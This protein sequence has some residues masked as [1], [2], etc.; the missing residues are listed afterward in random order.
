[1]PDVRALDPTTLFEH[2]TWMRRLAVSL[3]R[4]DA[5]ADDLVQDAWSVALDNPPADG[6]PLKAWLAGILKNQ[7]RGNAR[8]STHRKDRE[9]DAAQ[10]IHGEALVATDEIVASIEEQRF[11]F[12][13]VLELPDTYREV[14]LLRF[15]EG[16]AP[17]HI[18]AHLEI[19]VDTVRT[20]IRR[21]LDRLREALDRRHDGDRRAW[22]IAL[23]P[24]AGMNIEAKVAAAG[25]AAASAAATGTGSGAAGTGVFKGWL[26]LKVIVSAFVAFATLGAVWN[27]NRS[28]APLDLRQSGGAESVVAVLDRLEPAAPDPRLEPIAADAGPPA[29]EA[30]IARIRV[31]DPDGH[32]IDGAHLHRSSQPDPDRSI[33]RPGALRSGG[34]VQT[35]AA[36]M[37]EVRLPSDGAL[38]WIQPYHPD[39][40]VEGTRPLRAGDL[41]ITMIPLARTTLNLEVVDRVTGTELSIVSAFAEAILDDGAGGEEII[42][43]GRCEDHLGRWT[44]EVRYP[45]GAEIQV[46]AMSFD[47]LILC[48][49]PESARAVPVAGGTTDFR[50]KINL[51]GPET[52]GAHPLASGIVKDSRTGAPI[53]GATI[54]AEAAPGSHVNGGRTVISRAD[55]SFDLALW[56]KPD[57]WLTLR[58]THP[59]FAETRVGLDAKQGIRIAMGPKAR[60]SGVLIGADGAPIAGLP[61]DLSCDSLD[62]GADCPADARTSTNARGAFEFEYLDGGRYHL[63]VLPHAKASASSAVKSLSLRV[64]EGAQD[65]IRIELSRRDDVAVH[66]E[67]LHPGNLDYALTPLFLPEWES[68]AWSRAKPSAR[69][70]Y[71]AGLLSPG[72][73]LVFLAPAIDDH[74]GPYALLPAVEVD[75]LGDTRIDLRFPDGRIEGSIELPDPA[76]NYRVVIVP[77][78]GSGLAADFL[79]KSSVPRLLGAEV[80]ANGQF[81][82]A[83]VAPGP[84]E[85]RLYDDSDL[86]APVAVKDLEIAGSQVLAR[87]NP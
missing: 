49:E 76:V 48:D 73:Y 45:R 83:G 11:L 54:Q 14:V 20:R 15:H 31:V 69:R 64:A 36:G 61:I 24:L 53:A 86:S 32:P 29:R 85:I 77:K 18:A 87:W 62:A 60:V 67:V 81:V 42:R 30:P 33:E 51:E 68:G 59:R 44:P 56:A 12:D 22:G 52:E 38:D 34:S 13:A 65:A 47:G 72:T 63:H 43:L 8:K 66:G 2:T 21:G 41:E 50:I 79:N 35:D 57:T 4:D 5:R 71:E 74:N 37:A 23:L 80:A 28:P 1:M 27:S 3:V 46:T 17:R 10:A 19:P 39:F 40:L 55:G 75:G 9:H 16:L 58:A 7:A 78:V 82:L 84:S 26:S 25:S 6:V 70:R